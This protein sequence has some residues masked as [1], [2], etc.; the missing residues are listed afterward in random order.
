[1]T[2]DQFGVG[3]D[4]SDKFADVFDQSFNTS[5]ALQID[6][7]KSPREEVVSKMNHV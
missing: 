4:L 7:R 2:G 3:G 1:M 6:K 5:A